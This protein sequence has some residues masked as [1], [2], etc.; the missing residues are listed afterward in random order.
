MDL[1]GTPFRITGATLPPPT[2]PPMLGQHTAEVLT[3]LLGMDTAQLEELHR[4]G[5]I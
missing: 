4:Q 3:N 2:A 5:V 1:I